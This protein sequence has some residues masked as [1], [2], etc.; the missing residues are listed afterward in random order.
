MLA[1][2]SKSCIAVTISWKG[3]D[4]KSQELMYE[5]K[6]VGDPLI[7]LNRAREALND[8]ESDNANKEAM[9]KKQSQ[10]QSMRSQPLV[11]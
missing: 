3:M 4:I 9:P 10:E 6:K 5:Y 7:S 8:T 11:P 1:E 2:I